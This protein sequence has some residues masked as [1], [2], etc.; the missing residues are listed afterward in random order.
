MNTKRFL[1][2][3][4]VVIFILIMLPSSVGYTQI[5]QLQEDSTDGVNEANAQIT[6]VMGYQGRLAEG[7]V[8][9]TGNRSMKFALYTAAPSGGTKVWE[10]GP[11]VIAVSNGLFYTALGETVAFD[12]TIMNNMDQNL[13]LEVT[14]E[15]TLLPRQRLTGSPYAFSLAPGADIEGNMASGQ[16]VLKAQNTGDGWGF[17]GQAVNGY[18]VYGTSTNS[19]GVY[20][21]GSGTGLDGSGVLA[22]T[23]NTSGI[24]MWALSNS[25]DTTLVSSNNG[26]GPLYK[27]FGS[28]GGEHEFIVLN[29][30]TVQQARTASGLA[31]AAVKA[32]CSNSSPGIDFSFNNVGGTITIA[33]GGDV[34]RCQI[35]FGFQ[36]D[37][38][39]I[40]AMG[41]GYTTARGATCLPVS[42]SPNKIEC[43]RYD[44]GGVGVAGVI[45]VVIY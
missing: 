38:R 37:D 6:P 20:G 43:L 1:T 44:A 45:Y 16:S 12:T 13:W 25:T 17:L 11:K 35:D 39:Y 15:G 21:K 24:A 23:T 4:L 32:I 26:T 18:G 2:Y 42:G 7:G 34:G 41:G 3:L 10:E 27:G 14:V 29:D 28:N 36:V 19:H 31:K 8:P 33:A 30:G 22:E 9:V 40:V 5:G